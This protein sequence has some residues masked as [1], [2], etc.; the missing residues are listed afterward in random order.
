MTFPS[1]FLFVW[2]SKQK[3]NQCFGLDT[4]NHMNCMNAFS[5]SHNPIRTINLYV[6]KM[7]LAD[8]L[9][10]SLSCKSSCCYNK[11]N[12]GLYNKLFI[13]LIFHH[14]SYVSKAIQP[15]RHV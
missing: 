12:F 5:S 7:A 3:H 13:S 11:Y 15:I 8:K 2:Y 14:L 6:N 9:L 4:G 1:V 10:L